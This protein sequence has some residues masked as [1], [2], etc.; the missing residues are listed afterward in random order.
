MTEERIR[1]L[2]IV[3]F[4]WETSASIWNVRF[5]QLCAFKAQFGHCLVP[6]QYTANPKLGV[7]AMLET[8]PSAPD[9]DRLGFQATRHAQVK[10]P[11][12]EPNHQRAN[13]DRLVKQFMKKER[14][15]R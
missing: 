12:R 7:L 6:Q 3:E 11:R 4:E 13:D 10:E 14:A 1:E 5:Q 8:A 9:D 15:K 2:E